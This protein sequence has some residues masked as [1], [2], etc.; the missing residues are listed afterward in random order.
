MNLDAGRVNEIFMSCLFKEAEDK[1]NYTVGQGVMNKCG[2]HPERL[3]SYRQEVKELCS[4]L[5]DEFHQGKG[6]GMSFLNACMDR[7]GNHWAEHPTIDMLFILANALGI[8][9]FCMPREMWGMLPGGMPYL[10][11]KIGDTNENRN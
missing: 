6:G 9:S 8:A 2:F 3:E 10:V 11:F 5:P 7:H 4:E 1:S